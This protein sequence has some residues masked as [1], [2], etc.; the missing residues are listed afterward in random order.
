MNLRFRSST[1]G[2][3]ERHSVSLPA[4]KL[5][6]SLALFVMMLYTHS[7][8]A[9]PLNDLPACISEADPEL[10]VSTDD[11]RVVADANSGLAL[12]LPPSHEL[13]PSGGTWYV[14]GTLEGEPLVP[15][16]F[17]QL[18]GGLSVDE[19]ADEWFT[20]EA[21]LEPVRLG[22]ATHG[23]RVSLTGRAG[24]EGYLVTGLAGTYSIIRYEDFDW[25]SFDQVACSLHFIELVSIQD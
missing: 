14:Y 23:F 25:E 5:I 24:A 10:L 11:W 13:A 19:V 6:T 7:L 15:D 22:P 3:K 1:R 4:A 8:A 16:V 21:T 2:S 18:H 12:L 17:I 20:S 9:P